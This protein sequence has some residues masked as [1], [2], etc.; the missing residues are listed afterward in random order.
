MPTLKCSQCSYRARGDTVGER[1]AHLRKHQQ[2]KHPNFLSKRIKSGMKKARNTYH[3]PGNPFIETVKK[4]LDPSWVGFAER[5]LI[6]KITGRP[7]EE[8]RKQAVDAFVSELF[9][10]V[11]K[12][13]K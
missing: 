12:G 11:I 13:L 5:P 1:L 3:A 9:K 10:G 7:Y 4:I 6:E 8:V 2:K